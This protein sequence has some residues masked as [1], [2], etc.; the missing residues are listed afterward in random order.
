MYCGTILGNPDLL[1]TE[2]KKKNTNKPTNQTHK[3]ASV[4]K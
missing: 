3:A 4:K 1:C 2:T